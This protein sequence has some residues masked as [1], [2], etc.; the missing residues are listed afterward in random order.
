MLGEPSA[1]KRISR[2]VPLFSLLCLCVPFASAQSSVNFQL[3]FGTAHDSA[4]NTGLDSSGLNECSPTG[5]TVTATGGTCNS[6]PSLGGFF[7]GIGGDIMLWKHLGVGAEI[8]VQPAHTNYVQT[9]FG[10]IQ[11]RQS[12]YDFNAIYAPFNSKRASLYLEAGPGGSRTSLSINESSCVGSACTSQV[13]PI[14]SANH[15][16]V[17]AGIGLS[18]YLTEHFYV[19]PAFDIHYVPNFTTQPGFNS[20]LVTEGTVWV[21]YT[22]GER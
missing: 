18:L 10:P 16:Q 20:N 11:Y 1:V 3:G 9:D 2:Y 13:A 7:L 5:S 21:G 4:A 19:R 8:N 17:H 14:A 12:F 15:F 22:F 6:T